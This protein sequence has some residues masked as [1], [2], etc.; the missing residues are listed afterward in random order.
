MYL[1]THYMY[2]QHV[3]VYIGTFKYIYECVCVYICMY[4]C[5]YI[6]MSRSLYCTEI[7]TV[8][9]PILDKT[10]NLKNA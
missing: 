1:Y 3:Y 4:I 2:T 8:S 7:D 9:Q 10:I 6:C 5:V